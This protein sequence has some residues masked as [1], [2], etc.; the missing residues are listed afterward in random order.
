MKKAS[1]ATPADDN[2]KEPANEQANYTNT[3]ASETE[4]K[5]KSTVILGDSM[6]KNIQ[7]WELKNNFQDRERVYVKSFPGAT[8]DEMYSYSKPSMNRS[9]DSVIMHT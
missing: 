5:A 2:A 6:T 9:P 1:S 4:S 3:D 7:G 8:I